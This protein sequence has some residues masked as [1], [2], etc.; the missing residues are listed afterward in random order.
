MESTHKETIDEENE[1]HELNKKF[2]S[3]KINE[4][5][6]YS[7]LTSITSLTGRNLM[8]IGDE[9]GRISFYDNRIN[10]ISKL[11]ISD[12]KKEIKYIIF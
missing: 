8:G 1:E 9:T 3:F 7:K 2:S 6:L 4:L 11:Y 12:S 5:N 10:K